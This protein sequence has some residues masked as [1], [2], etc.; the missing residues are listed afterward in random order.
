MHEKYKSYGTNNNE[1]DATEDTISPEK[2]DTAPS[3]ILKKTPKAG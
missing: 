1:D 3:S 2:A